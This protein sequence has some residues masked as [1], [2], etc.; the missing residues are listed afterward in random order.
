MVRPVIGVV[1]LWDEGKGSLWMLP[2]Y[3]D[4]VER[5]GG[6][7]LMLPLS[8]AEAVWRQC[9]EL[10]D[11]FLVTGG[12]DVSPS[13][14]GEETLPLCGE[15][16]P[17]R[18]RMERALF[19]AAL[20]ADKPGL[21]SCR[22]IQLFNALLGGSLY[23]DIPAQMPGA[24]RHTQKPPYDRPVHAIRV[25]ADSPLLSLI[26]QE[27]LAV[28]SYHHQGIKCLAPALKVMAAAE[29]GLA[30]AVWM[31]EKH[32]VWAVQWHPEFALD[33]GDSRG[34]FSALVRAV[35]G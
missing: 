12:Q 25:A 29:D 13:L 28:N 14:Y 17:A 8:A 34:L 22:G 21:G 2:G 19:A 16:C 30:E 11:G 23:Q 4:G 24:V 18:D 5:A 35:G 31:P 33:S 1:P 27:T 10:C 32:F 7:P 6:L 3:M 26:G 15:L 9:V 20:A